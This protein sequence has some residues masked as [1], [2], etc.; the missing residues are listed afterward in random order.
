NLAELKVKADAITAQQQKI[1]SQKGV[2]TEAVLATMGR[3]LESMQRDAQSKQAELTAVEQNLNDDLLRDF[4]DKVSPII[5]ALR[6]EK[7]LWVIFAVQDAENPGMVTIASANE[8]LN[9]SLEIVK[10]LDA[11]TDPSG[12]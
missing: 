2:V 11:K 9:L 3:Q 1:D 8:G 4:Q 5:E 7:G 12:K 10:R 6:I